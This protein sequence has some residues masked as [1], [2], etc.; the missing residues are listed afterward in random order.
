MRIYLLLISFL[1]ISLSGYSQLAISDVSGGEDLNNTTYLVESNQ[2]DEEI[3]H[4]FVVTNISSSTYNVGCRRIELDVEAGV[5]ME[6][7]ICWQICPAYVDVGEMEVRVS[8]FSNEMTPGEE[9]N[10]FAMHLKP[11]G[12]D[13]CSTYRIEWFNA[14]NDTEVLGTVDMVFDHSVGSCLVGLD[15]APSIETAL[16]PNPTSDIA[17]L[18]ITGVDRM[19]DV[20]IFD[21]LGQ[22]IAK[23][24]F[25]PMTADRFLIDTSSMGNGIYFVSIQDET[26][27]LK[28]IK[29]VVKH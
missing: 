15:E 11:N 26:G 2:S 29:L 5:G 4:L 8:P 22:S 27:V 24:R 6:S 1:L 23:E 21:L 14:D 13:G 3:E 17:S 19:V 9:D 16:A 25:N 10:T 18:T 28:T 12:N 7:T 20:Q